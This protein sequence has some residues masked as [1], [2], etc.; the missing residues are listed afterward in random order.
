[1]AGKVD[2]I[3]P[4]TARTLD[5]LFSERVRRSAQS[6]AYIEFDENADAWRELTWFEMDS[7]IGRWQAALEREPLVPGDRIA[8]MLRNCTAWV[9]LDQAA[10][11]LGLVVVPLYTQDR[12]DN[13]AYIIRNSGAKLLLFE[14][15]EQWGAFAD[16]KPQLSGLVRVLC[17]KPLTS[18]AGDPRVGSV[19]TWLPASGAEEKHLNRDGAQL[20]SIIYTSGTTGKPKGVMLSHHNMLSNASSTL[21]IFDVTTEDTFLS[22]LPLSHTLERTC[23]YYLTTMAGARVAYARS[24]PQLAE[25]LALI[26]PT[27]LISVPRIYERVYA[28]IQAKLAEGPAFRRKLFELAATVGWASFEHRQGRGAWKPGMLLLPVLQKL[29]G[30]KVLARL[31]GRLRAAVSGGA[32]L[33]PDVAK[34]FIGLGL[35][36]LQGYGMTETSPVVASNRLDNNLPASIGKPIPN[37]EVKIGD[38]DAL[39]VKGPNVMLG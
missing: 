12:P 11:R 2:V 24:I 26:R 22:F 6:V 10:M 25:D 31:G 32:A 17:L 9:A 20:A 3:L 30:D 18:D 8:I 34:V 13:V 19:S 5:G 38:R 35:P 1:M 37:V 36:L 21:Q 29:V 15:P 4:E 27:L 28:A 33:P 14:K 16:V 23:G 39:L 7:L